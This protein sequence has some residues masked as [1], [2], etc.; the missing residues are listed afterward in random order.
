MKKV[1]LSGFTAMAI[2]AACN[3]DSTTTAKDTAEDTAQ[4]DEAGNHVN[5][6]TTDSNNT[7]TTSNSTGST[8]SLMDIMNK[9]MQEMKSMQSTGNP[10]NDYANMMKAHHLSAIEMAQ[11][12]VAQGSDANLKAMA[13]KMIDDQQKDVAEFNSFLSGHNAHGGGDAFHKEAMAMMNNMKMDM[14]MSGPVDKQF[15]QMMITHHQQAVDMSNSYLKNGAH[16]EKIKSMA[17]KIKAANQKEKEQL[18]AWLSKN[19]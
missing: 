7:A 8:A 5:T 12:E 1:L 4:H 11:V 15:A 17:N 6:G 19:K 10:D 2:L 16:E 9:S 18:Q 13:Q 14:D 3:N